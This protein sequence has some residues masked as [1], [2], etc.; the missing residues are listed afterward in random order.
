MRWRLMSRISLWQ[1]RA[2]SLSLTS[3]VPSL[4]PDLPSDV[5]MNILFVARRLHPNYTDSLVA[6]SRVHNLKVLVAKSGSPKE[7]IGELVLEQIETWVLAKLLTRVIR[8]LLNRQANDRNRFPSVLKLIR[9]VKSNNIELVYARRDNRIFFN[10]V[11]LGAVLSFVPFVTYR[12]EV[13]DASQK[14]DRRSVYPLVKR[15]SNKPE[16]VQRPRN[17]IPLSIDVSRY[18]LAMNALDLHPQGNSPLRVMAVGRY[19]YRKGH[20]L[21]IEA[22]EMIQH[23]FQILVDIYGG[24]GGDKSYEETLRKQVREARLQNVVRFM[25]LVSPDSMKFEYPK[26]HI[27]VYAGWVDPGFD[28]PELT[29][30]RADGRSGTRLYSMLEAMASGLP[31]VCAAE[32]HVVGAVDE[33]GNGL[34]FEKHSAVDLCEKIA[35]IHTMNLSKM[36]DH[37]RR[38]VEENYSAAEFPEKFIG[39]VTDNVIVDTP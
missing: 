12:Q 17:Y 8:L 33:G 15:S 13:L 3:L 30:E 32:R 38:L 2:P 20:H 23:R 26:H 11:R 5:N 7:R 36:G 19:I 9:Y 39:L 37:S 1:L 4:N 31:I 25:P 22:A 34:V 18:K 29:F 27:F 6:L 28:S 16:N 24:Y 14:Y 21:L 35:C 10:L